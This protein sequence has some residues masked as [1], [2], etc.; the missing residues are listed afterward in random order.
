MTPNFIRLDTCESQ[1]FRDVIPSHAL[2]RHCPLDNGH[3]TVAFDN[4]KAPSLGTLT[5]LPVEL[6]LQVILQ[7]DVASLLVWMRVNK[8]AMAFVWGLFEWHQVCSSYAT[9]QHE[10]T[11]TL[12]NRLYHLQTPSAW[13]SASIH[14]I[15]SPSPTSCP[16]SMKTNAPIALPRQNTPTFHPLTSSASGAPA[17]GPPSQPNKP[18]ATPC[19]KS[20]NA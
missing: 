1:F 17:S 8:R 4:S 9:G 13:L 12:P 16:P 11:L 15:L 7:L 6:Q 20:G 14:T 2:A 5:R 10:Y 18:S 19:G 3:H